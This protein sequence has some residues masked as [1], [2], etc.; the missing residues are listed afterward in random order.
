MGLLN[1]GSQHPKTHFKHGT[2]DRYM[3]LWLYR[4]YLVSHW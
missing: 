4:V 2:D 3:D 1:L